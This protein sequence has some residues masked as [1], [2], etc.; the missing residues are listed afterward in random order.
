MI[1]RESTVGFC[2]SEDSVSLLHSRQFFGPSDAIIQCASVVTM[3]KN[4]QIG[5]HQ[6]GEPVSHYRD[7]NR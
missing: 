5:F 2:R 1:A 4:V 3:R 6:K 7:W